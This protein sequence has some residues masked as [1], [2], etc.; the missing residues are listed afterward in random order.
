LILI[1]ALTVVHVLMFVLL[2]LFILHSIRIKDDDTGTYQGVSLF[3]SIE[4][5]I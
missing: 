2:R 3:I 5:C 4:G 1:F